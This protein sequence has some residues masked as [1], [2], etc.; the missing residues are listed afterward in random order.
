MADFPTLSINPSYPIG[1]RR[2]DSVVKTEFDAG[3][4]QR[5]NKHS[6]FRYIFNLQYI[7]IPSA[8][9]VLLDAFLVT[10]N[11]GADSFNWTHPQ[12]STVYVVEFQTLPDYQY[13]AYNYYNC[14]FS[15]RSI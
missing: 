4:A 11:G 1:E 15:L 14:N 10:V 13:A 3:Y 6:R 12:S 8:D 2:E 9:K 7:L 5:R